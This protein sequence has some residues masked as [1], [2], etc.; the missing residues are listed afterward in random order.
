[1]NFG[2]LKPSE[3]VSVIFQKRYLELKAG[4]LKLVHSKMDKIWPNS[5][6]NWLSGFLP[7]PSD[8]M[9]F[10]L[11][12]FAYIHVLLLLEVLSSLIL[13]P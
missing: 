1:M 10:C 6:L 7:F 2:G 13:D 5:S 9:R 3:Q 4:Q 11:Y 12:N 8:W